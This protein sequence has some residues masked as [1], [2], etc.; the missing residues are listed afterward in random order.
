MSEIRVRAAG[1]EEDRLIVREA[2]G[3]RRFVAS[4]FPVSV[5]GGGSATIVLAGRPSATEAW[6]GLHED[7][8]FVQPAEGAE[9]LY[10]GA[11]VQ[12]STWLKPGDVV[13]LGAARLRFIQHEGSAVLE[14]DD[15]SS[16]NITA[17][18]IVSGGARMYGETDGEAE[19][20]AAIPFRAGQ[21]VAQRRGIQFNPVRAVLAVVALLVAAVLWFIFTAVSVGIE[22]NPTTAKISVDGGLLAVPVG[23]RFLLR[24]GTYQVRAVEA[25]YTPAESKIDVTD[26]PD[27]QFNL[28]LEKLPG[29]LHIDVPEATRVSID[30]KERGT[31]PGD[32]EL[33]PG[34]HTVSIAAARYQPFTADVDIEGLGKTQTFKPA[35]LP[36]WADVSVASEP[37]GAQVFVDGE[38]RGATPLKTQILAGSHPV[39]LRMEGFKAWTTDIQVKANEPMTL[40]PVRLGLPDGRLS[41][42]S[43][44]AG[45]NVSIG[46]VYRGQTPLDVE[47]RSDVAQ[48]V[49][50]TQAGYEATTRE[51]SVAP[52]ER[53][54][55]SVPMNGVFGEISI[56]GQPADAQV[57]VDG[58]ASGTV[59]QTLRLVATS[60][61]IEVR[62]AGLV[63]FKTTVTPRP[64]LPQVVEAT[65][66]TAEQTRVAS[67][68]A[69][70]TT[71][72]EQQLKLMPIGRFTAGSPRR[73]PGRRP[74]EGQHDVEFKRSFYLSAQEVTNAAFRRFRP[75][76]KSGIAG[77]TTLDLENQPVVA[78]SWESAAAYC[79]W[80]SEQEGL[81]LAYK[82]EGDSYVAVK[83]VTTGYRLPT[84]AEWEWAARY[85]GADKF[86]RYPWGDSLPVAAGSGN[87]A[88]Y[89]ARIVVQDVIPDYD[90]GFIASAPVGKFPPNPLGLYDMGGNVAEWAHD[91]YTVSADAKQVAVDP[92]GPEQ[93][94]SHVIRGSSWR[95]S[96]VTDLRL[97]ARDF[98]DSARNDV[99]FR[100]ARYVE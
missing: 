68:P 33:A 88:D 63:D 80:L 85:S 6:I 41:V 66:L 59:N 69:V 99:G 84:D 91:Y 58:K 40:G 26:A 67:I 81:P 23:N 43:E 95:Q 39:E 78:V 37:A 46:G 94:K 11:R 87:Y 7:Q 30:G 97:S 45:A 14:I 34:R 82:R 49:V 61:E 52:G 70:I 1:R 56:R 92:L 9:V 55:L 62:K 24:P 20:I 54:T 44:P 83:P 38:P 98:G 48:S 96:S 79:N 2:L 19:P 12:R 17:P 29:R 13:N 15:G 28:T 73:E 4:E 47:L 89:T 86:R 74:N 76:H 5:G 64:G 53:K 31:A 3:E 22:P 72:A 93:G 25:G 27:Q 100:I 35:L 65:L 60:H 75:E 51:V 21:S 8:L 10:N 32:F 50:I 16:G 18:P 77:P 90:D 71:K 57:F 36:A 42:R